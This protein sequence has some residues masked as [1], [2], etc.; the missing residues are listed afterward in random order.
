MFVE[1]YSTYAP[2]ASEL[3]KGAKRGSLQPMNSDDAEPQILRIDANG[4]LPLTRPQ[5]GAFLAQASTSHDLVID[6]WAITVSKRLKATT[7][8]KPRPI[9]HA[10]M[11]V[12]VRL[13]ETR[14]PLRAV[15]LGVTDRTVRNARFAAEVRRNRAARGGRSVLLFKRGDVPSDKRW[16]F[17]T[18]T[19]FKWCLLRPLRPDDGVGTVDLPALTSQAIAIEC[20]HAQYLLD[21]RFVVVVVEI[22][23]PTGAHMTIKRFELEIGDQTLTSCHG[24]SSL[25]GYVSDM[26]WL[27]RLS[28]HLAAQDA[29]TGTLAFRID[30][31]EAKTIPPGGVDA[32]LCAWLVGGDKI[33]FRTRV[34]REPRRK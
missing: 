15:D 20:L 22:E 32:V 16:F 24:P 27:K 4:K 5:Y 30:D 23:N 29:K 31:S 10:E 8:L 7:P 18:K 21:E 13:I 25:P 11:R 28:L 26:P 6:A 34:Q 1:G 9:Q 14:V 19:D 33:A 3:S 17:E 2:L 12:L